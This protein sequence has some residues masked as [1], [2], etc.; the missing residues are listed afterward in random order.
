M[1]HSETFC[2][3][4][5]RLTQIRINFEHGYGYNEPWIKWARKKGLIKFERHV[6]G[7]W[8]SG[9]GKCTFASPT[10]KGLKFLQQ[11]A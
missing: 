9:R 11:N 3:V 6:I 7:F 10:E 4:F 5:K 8:Y 1:K 2:L